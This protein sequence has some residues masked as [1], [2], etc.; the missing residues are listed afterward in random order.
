MMA[1]I[2]GA[3]AAKWAWVLV[4]I[5]TE[6]EVEK[7]IDWYK[8][9][10]RSRPIALQ[11]VHD[12]WWA[13]AWRIALAMRLNKTFGEVTSEIM[14]DVTAFQEAILIH[15]VFPYV[16]VY[17]V[18]TKHLPKKNKITLEITEIPTSWYISLHYFE[19]SPKNKDKP[20]KNQETLV[21]SMGSEVLIS[22]RVI[23]AA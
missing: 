15:N 4:G 9:K 17:Q 20:T 10:A 16:I 8:A 22:M 5:G 11:Q 1:I 23:L 13:C 6:D 19:Q 14:M 21:K 3:D 2:D 12:Y 18:C 7:Y